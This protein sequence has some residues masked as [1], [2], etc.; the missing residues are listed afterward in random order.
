VGGANH[1]YYV[2]NAVCKAAQDTPSSGFTQVSLSYPF[3]NGF[4]ATALATA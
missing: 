1:A 2:L 3:M 4:T